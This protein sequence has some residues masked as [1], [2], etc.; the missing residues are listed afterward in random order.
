ME[1][2]MGTKH[3]L[4]LEERFWMYVNKGDVKECW[5]W[6]GSL[7]SKGYGKIYNGGGAA[8]KKLLAAHRVSYQMFFG[9]IP[10]G[11]YVCHKCDNKACV[12]PEHL[13]LGTAKDNT[14]DMLNKGRSYDRGGE[15]NNRNILST[16]DVVKIKKLLLSETE[17]IS[18][19]AK[20]F[21]VGYN[22]IWYIAA[23]K[24]W[25]KI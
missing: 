22:V 14:Q 15:N 1:V 5:E 7:D 4:S 23:G 16:N 10:S 9:S 24:T 18:N 19:I 3:G 21:D 2:I 6:T 12:N 13:F 17:S 25:K 8:N 20:K 11:L